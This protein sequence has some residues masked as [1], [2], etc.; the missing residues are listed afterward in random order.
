VV[1]VDIIVASPARDYRAEAVRR[2]SPR[3]IFRAAA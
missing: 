3:K 2:G 1:C